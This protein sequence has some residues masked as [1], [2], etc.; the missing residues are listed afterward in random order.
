MS[1]KRK[2]SLDDLTNISEKLV[3]TFFPSTDIYS[4]LLLALVTVSK[5]SRGKKHIS[6][7][8][9]VELAIAYAPDLIEYL[10]EQKHVTEWAGSVL[11]GEL[12]K[13]REELPLIFQ[14]YIYAAK[15]LRI[16]TEEKNGGG[17]DRCD[18]M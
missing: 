13:M 16:K 7:H 14:S 4:L 18:V 3:D 2:I 6:M 1:D 15:G 5:Y 12:E 8:T 10:V 17:K 9:R 11:H